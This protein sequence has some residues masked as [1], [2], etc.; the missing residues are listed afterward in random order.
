M[1]GPLKNA[2]HERFAQELAKGKS[3]S[4]AYKSAGY[5]AT[6]NAA[7]SAA[8]RLVRNV[9]VSGRVGQL[10]ARAAERA[11]VTVESITQRLLSIA[12]KGEGKEDAS[13]LS[14]ARASLMDAAKLN[15]L[16]IDRSKVGIDLS[17]LS[18]E[19]LDAL[20]RILARKTPDA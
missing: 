1:T 5:S 9:Q 8:A 7:E 16:I 6:G 15:G 2:R 12:E 20:D 11:V 19:D 14:V 17:D 3:Q 10:K 4:E 18:E 13:L